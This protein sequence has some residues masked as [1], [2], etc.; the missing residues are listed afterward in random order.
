MYYT[1]YDLI[2]NILFNGSALPSTVEGQA[3]TL[4]TLA[5]TVFVAYLPF[6]AMVQ[7]VNAILDWRR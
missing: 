1:L 5:L 4:I 7:I 3:L 6:K 2:N